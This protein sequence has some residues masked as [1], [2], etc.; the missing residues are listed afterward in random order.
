MGLAPCSA[1]S[2]L[3]GMLSVSPERN[4]YTRSIIRILRENHLV[5]DL[6]LRRWALHL[7]GVGVQGLAARLGLETSLCWLTLTLRSRALVLWQ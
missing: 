3:P 5:C 2:L 4:T 7:H 6:P 1:N